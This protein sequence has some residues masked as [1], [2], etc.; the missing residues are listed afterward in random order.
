MGRMGSWV[1]NCWSGWPRG[2]EPIATD[3]GSWVRLQP[4]SEPVVA[5]GVAELR[6]VEAAFGE[7]GTEP[8]LCAG[9]LAVVVAPRS[10]VGPE[11]GGGDEGVLG[12]D[13]ALGDELADDVV[14]GAVLVGG[15]G[16]GGWRAEALTVPSSAAVDDPSQDA[17]SFV[18]EG[19]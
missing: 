8:F 16:D 4:E 19:V 7:R 5:A 11:V 3:P 1:R 9:L 12:H 15:E 17:G 2:G 14:V 10:P 13:A 18:G 6:S